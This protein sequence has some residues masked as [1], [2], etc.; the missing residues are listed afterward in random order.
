MNF[1][2]KKLLVQGAGRGHLGLVKTAKEM[3][4]YIVMTGLPG[5][6]PCIPYADKLC[7]ANIADTD[8]ILAVAKKESVDGIVICC[9]D[10]G[11]QSVGY[12]CDKLH[13]CGL[14]EKSAKMSSNKLLMKQALID[15]G[16]R[17]AKFK[18]LR[19][20]NDVQ[21]A[22]RNLSF[23]LIVKATDLQGSRGIFIVQDIDALK[24]GFEEVMSET[25]QSFCIVEEFIEGQEF[26]AQSFVYKGKILFI[27]PHGDETIM[28]ATAVPIG[29]YMPLDI[30]DVSLCEDILNQADKAIKAIGL[31]N[32]AINIDFIVKDGKA[33]VIELTGRVGANCLPELTS[34]Y[35]G[36]NYY[37][38]II[39]LSLGEDP[40]IYFNN[41]LLRP[42]ATISKMIKSDKTGFVASIEYPEVADNITVEMFVKRGS[43]IHRFTNSNDAI[44]QVIIA[45]KNIGDCQIGIRQFLDKLKINF[46]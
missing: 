24:A 45:D 43:E 13:L 20:I 14:S 41:R 34:N 15:A 7:Y 18:E 30:V 46:K 39:A 36:I 19:N 40:T 26:G 5:D 3:G 21:M 35:W 27:L 9:S 32:C 42:K 4:I 11:L 33:Y 44:G 38:M 16:V 37:K 2:G 25:K 31:D 6:Y 12:V 29:H 28:C 23:P 10:I 8:E 22:I 17:T 1:K